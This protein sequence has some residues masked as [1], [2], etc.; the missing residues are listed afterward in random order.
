ML[1]LCS[2]CLLECGVVIAAYINKMTSDTSVRSFRCNAVG[3]WTAV[4]VAVVVFVDGF[5]A[6]VDTSSATRESDD[7]Y[8]LL[9]HAAV[10]VSDSDAVDRR[11]CR[12]RHASFADAREILADELPKLR[13]AQ[14]PRYNQECHRHSHPWS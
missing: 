5:P 6:V 3:M 13:L 7:W 2:L 10:E 11:G 14:R 4:L 8:V 12:T 9:R 1:D